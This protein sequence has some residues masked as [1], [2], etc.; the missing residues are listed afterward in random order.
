MTNLLDLDRA[1]AEFLEDGPNTAPEA[2]VIAALA[3]ARTTPRRPDPFAWLRPDA[4]AARSARIFGLRPGLVLAAI[5][6]VVA[7]VG[8]A[9]IGSR[10]QDQAIAP[11]GPSASPAGPTPAP[12]IGPTRT[13]YSQTITMLVSGGRAFPLDVSDTTGDLVE[14][15]SIQPGDGATVGNDEIT[16]AA[17]P[18]DPTALVVT[19]SGTP[20]ETTGSLRIDERARAIEIGRDSCSGDSLPLD[21]IVRLQFETK[22][23]TADWTTTFVG[24]PHE[25]FAAPTAD[26]PPGATATPFPAP[27]VL[28]AR[29]SDSSGRPFELTL[30]DR[31]ATVVSVTAVDPAQLGA[32][33]PGESGLDGISSGTIQLT[34]GGHACEAAPQLT[35]D[36]SGLDWTLVVAACDTSSPAVV[37]A[38]DVTYA[39]A[40]PVDTI[41]FTGPPGP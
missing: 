8:V 1:L 34:W 29:G 40:P 9:V 23:T 21:R 6:L 31:H 39:V 22:V 5:A 36:P 16:I 27:V 18:A 25:S 2:P 38:V 35:I 11:P 7:S 12:T 4:M 19:W 17:D 41:R 37:R 26:L 20:C 33:A 28:S 32:A 10:P 14:A 30:V 15:R 13:A 3:H 24:Q